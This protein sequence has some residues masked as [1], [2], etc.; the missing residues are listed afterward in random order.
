MTIVTDSLSKSGSLPDPAG[1]L[2]ASAYAFLLPKRVNNKQHHRNRDTRIGDV[3]RRPGIGEANVQIKKKKVDHVSVKQAICQI[4]QNPGK[5]KRERYIPPRVRSPVSH[6][7]NRHN[8]HRDDG[9]YNEES[10]VA[11]KR[12]DRGAGIGDVNQIEE[13][14]HYNPSIVKANG[15]HYPVLRQLVQSVERKREKEDELHVI[16]RGA[17]SRNLWVLIV[18]RAVGQELEI[19]RLR[20]T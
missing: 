16:S 12:S 18:W 11:L 17:K 1:T 3:K 2:F 9:N 20:S 8:D 13:V 14:R 15:S 7:Q 19:S 4:S 5:E 6:Q 10:V